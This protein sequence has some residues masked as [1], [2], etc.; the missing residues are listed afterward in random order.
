M[1]Q[2]TRVRADSGQTRA[3][4]D[5]GAAERS[6]LIGGELENSRQR[7]VKAAGRRMIRVAPAVSCTWHMDRRDDRRW[8]TDTRTDIMWRVVVD[9]RVAS[10]MS[11]CCSALHLPLHGHVVQRQPVQR[12][13]VCRAYQ[14]RSHEHSNV[15]C[16]SASQLERC[17][18]P[19]VKS[20]GLCCCLAA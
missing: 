14:R 16:Y 12:V 10:V 13:C 2:L 6:E 3:S 19:V 17:S 20:C 1:K 5:A 8:T 18:T 7:E 9:C 4:A 11:L 15:P